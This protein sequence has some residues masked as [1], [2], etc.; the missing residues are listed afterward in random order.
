[1][2]GGG[3]GGHLFPALALADEF[4][5]ADQSVEIIFIGAHGRL[6]E[7]VVPN[8]DYPL[9]LIEIE[10]IKNKSGFGWIKALIKAAAAT[11]RSIRMLRRIKP[12]GVIGSGS[13]ASG[14]VVL[15][16]KILGIKTALLEQNV[17][18]GITNKFLAKFVDRAYLS[19]KDSEKLFRP[20]THRL[21]GTPVRREILESGKAGRSDQNVR[22]GGKFTILVFGGS[23]GAATINATFL[24]AAEYLSDIWN[25]LRVI[26]QIGAEGYRGAKEAYDRKGLSVELHKFIDD[27][28]GAYKDADLVVCRAGATSI[29]EI[30]AL[31]LPSI[32]MPYPF[33]AAGHQEVNA[34]YLASRGA[35]VM[36]TQ[37]DLTA[38]NLAAVI[39]D[40]YEDRAKLR[41]TASKSAGLGRPEAARFI[42]NDFS[43]LLEGAKSA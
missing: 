6:E 25:D 34:R 1:M 26:H 31:G 41:S 19:F 13:Y 4:K 40:F 3:T 16:A 17:L 20:G 29:A 27:M 35:A 30:T 10:A 22:G 14:P 9:E 23:Q 36:I 43:I 32:M 38:S 2:A 18:P 37:D 5:A 8:F 42:V 21:S 7:K 33:A 28:A 15:A 24:D 39:K 12:D 11:L